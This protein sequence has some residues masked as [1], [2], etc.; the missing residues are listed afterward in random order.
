[1]TCAT[2]SFLL[3]FGAFGLAVLC[4]QRQGFRYYCEMKQAHLL[5]SSVYACEQRMVMRCPMRLLDDDDD[6]DDVDDAEH[7]DDA[8]MV[9]I[10]LTA[11]VIALR[12]VRSVIR[13][14][15][16]DAF[17]ASA[18][19]EPK[20]PSNPLSPWWRVPDLQTPPPPGE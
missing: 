1:M 8:R 7:Y 16:A 9:T 19:E 5:W 11:A 15:T 14:R 20:P 13:Y 12:A 3:W 2:V 17:D 18:F 6:D 10:A 4:L